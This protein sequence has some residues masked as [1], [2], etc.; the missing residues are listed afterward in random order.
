MKAYDIAVAKDETLPPWTIVKYIPL[1]LCNAMVD[2]NDG[3]RVATITHLSSALHYMHSCGMTPRDVKPDNVLV[4]RYKNGLTVKLAYFGTSRHHGSAQM[5]TFTGTE[6]YMAP[7]L[8][9]TPRRYTPKVDLWALGLVFVEVL[10]SWHPS[11]EDKWD[12]NYFGPWM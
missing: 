10:T 4:Q 3:E 5:D 11:H 12:R 8:F 6:L 7:E 9:F 2:L 1:N